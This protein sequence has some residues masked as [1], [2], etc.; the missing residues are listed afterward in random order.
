MAIGMAIDLYNKKK[1]NNAQTIK[2]NQAEVEPYAC[3]V[4]LLH[5]SAGRRKIRPVTGR[6]GVKEAVA[7]G[8][9]QMP[10]P[11]MQAMHFGR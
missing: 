9:D 1:T 3:L 6:S 5:I 11:Q 2:G 7:D 10:Q 8:S 4:P